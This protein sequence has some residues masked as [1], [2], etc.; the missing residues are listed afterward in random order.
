M[1]RLLDIKALLFVA[2]EKRTNGV[3]GL[4]AG[5]PGSEVRG[6]GCGGVGDGKSSLS[7]G[8]IVLSL[9]VAGWM[10]AVAGSAERPLTGDYSAAL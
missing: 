6:V 7:H 5:N 10:A 2:E 4:R 8:V 9:E 1:F 3:G